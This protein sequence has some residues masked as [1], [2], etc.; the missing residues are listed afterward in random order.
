MAP[1]PINIFFALFSIP[2]WTVGIGMIGTIIF[3]IF[4]T[5]RLRIS[6]EQIS[7]TY[8]CLKFKLQRPKPTTRNNIAEL[9]L[10]KIA[11]PGSSSKGKATLTIWADKKAFKIRGTPGNTHS[12]SLNS[13]NLT[14]DEVSWLAKDLSEW[15]DMPIRRK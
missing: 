10:S 12:T 3:T 4:G 8:E 1:S 15:L 9:N 2:F 6:P 7:L 5:T 11:L 14:V 13:H